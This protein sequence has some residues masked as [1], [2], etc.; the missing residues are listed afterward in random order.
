MSAAAFDS[1]VGERK[2]EGG[3]FGREDEIRRGVLEEEEEERE[4]VAEEE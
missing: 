3:R 2:D 1:V 4:G